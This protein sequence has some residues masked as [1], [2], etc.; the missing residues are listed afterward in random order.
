MMHIYDTIWDGLAQ[1]MKSY[2][3]EKE[4]TQAEFSK[5]RQQLQEVLDSGLWDGCCVELSEIGKGCYL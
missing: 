3:D 4:Q 5:F 2:D 1:A